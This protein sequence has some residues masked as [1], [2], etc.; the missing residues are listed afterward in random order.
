MKH[1]RLI[2]KKIAACWNQIQPIFHL[3]INVLSFCHQQDED[4]D[5]P[6][7]TQILVIQTECNTVFCQ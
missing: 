5:G 2:L 6:F 3:G 4:K 1:T 7:Y